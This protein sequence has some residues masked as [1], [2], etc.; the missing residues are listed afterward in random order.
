[1]VTVPCPA[2][3]NGSSLREELTKWGVV[4]GE[5]DFR[6]EKD[7]LVFP[8]LKDVDQAKVQQVVAAHTGA[9]TPGEAEEKALGQRAQGV[10]AKARAI[11]ADPAGSPDWAAAERKVIL[12]IL[13]VDLAK[14]HT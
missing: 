5:F 4:V 1:M 8:T 11:I 3:L 12:A 13:A 9:P 10:L 2:S 14:R 7:T 6:V